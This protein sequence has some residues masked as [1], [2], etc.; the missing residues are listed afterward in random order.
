MA[1][2]IFVHGISNKPIEKEL[3]RSWRRSLATDYKDN[4]GIDLADYAHIRSVHWADVL[5]ASPAEVSEAAEAAGVTPEAAVALEAGGPA[6]DGVDP[7][8]LS[9]L[10]AD[11][12]FQPA[13]LASPAEVPKP[14]PE[15]VAQAAAEA[16]PLPWFLK[17]PL[18]R[19][20]A[21][22]SHHYLFNVEHAP[23]PGERYSVRD[24]IRQRFVKTVS[25]AVEAGPVVL[26]GPV[27]KVP[28]PESD[29]R[30]MDEAEV[31]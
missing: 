18:L 10:G 7:E 20:F 27:D 23:R 26:L 5:Y 11:L 3:V 24:E 16:I 2:V 9:Q 17:K 19:A 13:E 15:A 1:T 21:R 31:A 22:D 28:D 29:G 12:S 14:S 25:E 6:V 4:S 8:F 30:D